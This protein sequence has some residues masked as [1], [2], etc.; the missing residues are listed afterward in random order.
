M[1]IGIEVYT[2]VFFSLSLLLR[3]CIYPA[4]EASIVYRGFPPRVYIYVEGG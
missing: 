4:E 2:Y 1:Y 3:V